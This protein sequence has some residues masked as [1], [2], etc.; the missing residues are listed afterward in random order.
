MFDPMPTAL[1]TA[2]DGL[3][4]FQQLMQTPPLVTLT[5]YPFGVLMERPTPQGRTAYLVDPQQIAL[6]LATT[7]RFETG[8]LTDKTLYVA[9]EGVQKIVVEYR[10]RQKTALFLEGLDH[11]VIIPLPPLLLFR[12]TTSDARP[13]Y[14]LFAVKKRP[15][16]GQAALFHAPLPNLYED[17]RVCWGTVQQLDTAQL[18]QTSLTDDWKMLLGTRF[19]THNAMNRSQ[20]Y[21]ANI[22]QQYLALEAAKARFYPVSDLVPARRTLEQVIEG[23]R[24]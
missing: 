6:Q 23:L 19:G 14:R 5:V 15:S 21:P 24:R 4:A 3:L 12:R 8:I 18:Q 20:R 10:P 7:L 11:P 2:S 17:G 22:C 13:E 9:Q 16:D 1:H